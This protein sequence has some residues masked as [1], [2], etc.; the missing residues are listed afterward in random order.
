M[1]M[2][3]KWRRIVSSFSRHW[4]A[5]IS[6]L[7]CARRRSMGTESI[8]SSTV[9]MRV[10]IPEP[11]AVVERHAPCGDRSGRA[12][13]SVARMV[14]LVHAGRLP[15]RHD[16][17]AAATEFRCVGWSRLRHRGCYAAVSALDVFPPRPSNLAC[18]PSSSRRASDLEHRN[19]LDDFGSVAQLVN[20]GSLQHLYQ[21]TDPL[22]TGHCL[23]A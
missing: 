18:R 15:D 21:K 6:A 4:C 3:G 1:N 2:A 10:L 12:G 8:A 9:A 20:P 7:I 23:I 14:E 13:S 5:R 16:V 11:R 19:C 22:T 17:P